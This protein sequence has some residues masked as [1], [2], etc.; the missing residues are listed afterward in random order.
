MVVLL[1]AGQKAVFVLYR[2]DFVLQECSGSFHTDLS[3]LDPIEGSFI[4]KSRE[5]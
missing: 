2:M 4:I 5:K 3:W 1:A